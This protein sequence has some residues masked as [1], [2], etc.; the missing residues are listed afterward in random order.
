MEA[1]I[2]LRL[3]INIY[4]CKYLSVNP[5]ELIL[6]RYIISCYLFV[7][8]KEDD[9]IQDSN[10]NPYYCCYSFTAFIRM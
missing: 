2:C 1:Q 10:Y 3:F 7:A 6:E 9:E 4:H 5:Y 8:P